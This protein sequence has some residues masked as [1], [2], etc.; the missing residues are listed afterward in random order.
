MRVVQHK[1]SRS[2]DK[3]APPKP[4]EEEVKEFGDEDKEIVHIFENFDCISLHLW[5][6]YKCSL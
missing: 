2:D 3:P 4:S 5:K 1:S 6:S